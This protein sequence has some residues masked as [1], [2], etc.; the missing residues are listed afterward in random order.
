MPMPH[1]P[2][3]PETASRFD[4]GARLEGVANADR[5]GVLD[6]ASTRDLAL[7]LDAVQ[8]APGDTVRRPVVVWRGEE[9]YVVDLLVTADAGGTLRFDFGDE[10]PDATDFDQPDVVDPRLDELETMVWVTDAD[11]LA[12]FFNTAW[13]A[14]TGAGLADDLG[15]GWMQRV[16]TDDLA[17]LLVAYEAAQNDHRGFEYVGRLASWDGDWWW[18]RVRAAPRLIDERFQGFLGICEVL[19]RATGAAPPDGAGV[20]EILPPADWRTE[21]P[22]A[23][24]SRLARLAAALDVTRPAEPIEVT[25]LR[26]LAS[27][28]LGQHVALV[29]RH[30][31]VVLAVGEAAANSALHAYPDRAG[32]VQLTCTLAPEHAEFRV[33]DWGMWQEPRAERESRG[34]ILMRALTDDCVV[35]HLPDGTEVVLRFAL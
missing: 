23:V 7:F 3:S 24:A 28:W 26:R 1:L 20:A 35:N 19:C 5:A 18:A 12:R 14:F 34:I 11:R 17:G 21:E 22:A 4:V 31:D 33:R 10:R 32:R 30:D 13:L 6:A 9:R 27:R 25:L 15:W 29:E 16:H 8:P 2:D